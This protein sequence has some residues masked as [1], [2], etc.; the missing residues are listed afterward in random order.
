MGTKK[1]ARHP[2]DR[3][4]MAQLEAWGISYTRIAKRAGVSLA[5]VSMTMHGHKKSPRV[6]D[7]AWGCIREAEMKETESRERSG[8]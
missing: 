4:L 8:R 2:M 6:I 1:A 3:H 5:L 7:S